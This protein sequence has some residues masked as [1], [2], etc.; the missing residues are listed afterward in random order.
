M[1]I[2]RS[3]KCSLKFSTEN[4]YKQLCHILTEYGNTVNQ[5]I[6]YF[7]TNGTVSK[8]KLLKPI[9]DIPNSW[10]SAR[11]RKVA[12][13]EALDMIKSTKEVHQ[14]NKKQLELSVKAIEQRINKT[15][16]DS[17]IN[18]RKLNNWG[19]S[20]KRK[21]NRLSHMQPT[22]PKHSGKR[23]HVSSTIAELQQPKK[24]NKFDNWLHLASI[25]N[26]I[27]LDIPI[28]LHKHF[29]I[30]QAKGKKLNDYI[31]TKDY[32][33]FCFEIE[34]GEKKEVKIA[35]GVDT[36]INA[37]ASTSD[38]KQF[39]TDI[40]EKINKIKRCQKGSKKQKSL[41]RG[42]K[43]RIDEVAK[44]IANKTDLVVVEKLKN[45]NNNTKL[46]G[47]LSKNI[48]SSIGSWNY[49][50]WLDRL[51]QKCE[52]NRV[53]FRTV[54]PSYTSQECFQCGYIDR[55]NRNGEK[56]RCM[57]CNHSCNADINAARNIL[58]RFLSGPYGATYKCE[59]VDF[60]TFL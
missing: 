60:T 26:K 46:K 34:T 58:E 35:L 13:R 23:M 20:L 10:L 12:A 54:C 14:S 5:F 44:E 59:L 53:T 47:R 6:D 19:K 48:R 36:G 51:Q 45:M 17:K 28:K 41:I 57:K 42:L 49:S 11:L 43:Q 52:E 27:I 50:Y 21:V 2:N 29:N 24:T 30:L 55:R 4:K 39:G 9:V 18:R 40:K 7:W 37:L 56:F 33:Q 16:P 31:I 1:K 3:T 32:V 22:K 38:S 15:K 8:T 25:G